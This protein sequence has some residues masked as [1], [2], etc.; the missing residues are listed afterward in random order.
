MYHLGGIMI[1]YGPL[2]NSLV[3]S[4]MEDYFENNI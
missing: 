4:V 2:F 3:S 1:V